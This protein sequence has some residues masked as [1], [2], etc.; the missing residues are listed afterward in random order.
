M[1]DRK[2]E[3]ITFGTSSYLKK[4]DLP[5]IRVRDDMVKG[6]D[7]IKFPG[8]ILDK[9][10]NMTK[11]IGAKDRTA[12][13]N[14]EKI[15]RVRKYIPEDETKM[16]VCSMVLSHL[17]YG[18]ATLVNHPNSI[19][20]S[21][22][23]TQNYAAKVTCKKWKCDSSTECLSTLHWLPIH[24]M[25]IYK[26]MTIVYKPLQEN[27]PQYLA[28]K[29]HITIMD[30]MTKYNKSNIK[31]LQVPFNKKKTHGDRGFS[32]TGPNYWNKLTNYIKEA[33]NLGKLK[34]YSCN[35]CK[36]HSYHVYCTL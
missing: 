20:K 1:N 18:N 17:D 34:K 15:E 35:I 33:E 11:Y 23:S 2:T 28:N 24:Y 14:L 36:S 8:L 6:S 19:L 16:P 26:P 9:E 5:E 27:E 12:H 30:R 31:L 13:F 21:L 22:Q 25:C 10:L 29:L 3:F 32:F 4:Q 7:T